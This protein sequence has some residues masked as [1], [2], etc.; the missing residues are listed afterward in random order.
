MQFDSWSWEHFI[1]QLRLQRQ[2]MSLNVLC[3]EIQVDRVSYGMY[4]VTE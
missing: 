4:I 2:I 1:Q 3:I